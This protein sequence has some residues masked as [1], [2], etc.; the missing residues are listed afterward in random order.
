MVTVECA[1]HIHQNAQNLVHLEHIA[2]T[3]LDA[4][5]KCEEVKEIALETECNLPIRVHRK[6]DKKPV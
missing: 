1:P 6:F 3:E 5:V 4:A 2:A